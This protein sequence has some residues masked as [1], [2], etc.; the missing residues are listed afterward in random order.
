MD[1]G[2]FVSPWTT[3]VILGRIE[4]A[5]GD[6][7]AAR[8]AEEEARRRYRSYRAAGGA[9]VE[10][11]CQFVHQSVRAALAGHWPAFRN[12][13][14]ENQPDGSPLRAVVSYI[15]A[16]VQRAERDE[17]GF[18]VTPLLAVELEMLVDS[19]SGM[20]RRDA[21]DSQPPS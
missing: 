17:I 18:E 13:V 10:D 9:P 20:H 19:L 16:Y 4:R 3:Y 1:P 11:E 2:L 15:D 21:V 14:T 8:T 5:A 6:E 7:T 12:A